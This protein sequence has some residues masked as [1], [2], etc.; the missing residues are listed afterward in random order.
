MPVKVM[1]FSFNAGELSREFEGR[2]DLDRYAAGAREITNFV[3]LPLGGIRRRYG[4]RFIAEAKSATSVCRLLP[5][6]FSVEQAYPLEFGHLYIRFFKNR[7]RL[8]DPPGT[9]VEVD[10]PYATTH[11]FGIQTAQS[12]DV[13]WMTQASA[14]HKLL[15]FSDTSW[16]TQ[17][18]AFDP[19]PSV[20]E[21]VIVG[22]SLS[23]GATTG[24]GIPFTAGAPIFFDANVG[25]TITL[26]PGMKSQARAVITALG[27]A[28]PSSTVIVNILTPFPPSSP[29]AA[30]QWQLSGP[31]GAGLR[32]DTIT[33][34]GYG[35]G[36]K[37]TVLKAL[38]V[39]RD[40]SATEL[41]H[42]REFRLGPVQLG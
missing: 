19:P 36:A 5:F 40:I 6:E 1:K 29:I 20:E 23:Y 34:S 16:D 8:E 21:P 13:M 4:T 3:T 38:L 27:S 39:Q 2:I 17:P 9:P 22:E 15:R 30:G 31:L 35:Q 32:L 14:Q 42:Q 28:S 25:R 26:V 37:G 18:I 10:S 33:T 24:S 41:D 11:L 7:T 12:A